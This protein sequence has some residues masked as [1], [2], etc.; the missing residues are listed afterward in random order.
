MSIWTLNDVKLK[1][2]VESVS[3]FEKEQIDFYLNAT[4]PLIISMFWEFNL[5]DKTEYF[6]LCN[7]YNNSINVSNSN[8]TALVSINWITYTWIK[9]TDYQIINKKIVIKDIWD[10]LTNI[11]FSEIEIVYTS[12]YAEIPKDIVYFHTLLVEWE[13]AKE[14]GKEISSEKLWPRTVQFVDTPMNRSMLETIKN[15]YLNIIF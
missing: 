12:W 11:E 2:W 10:Y 5:S 6:A 15:K 13:L 9:W 7:I 14:W 4:L 8:P 1:L 3:I